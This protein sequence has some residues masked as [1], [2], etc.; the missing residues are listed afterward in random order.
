[1]TVADEGE[2][3]EIELLLPWYAAGTLNRREAQRV[4]A[5]LAGDPELA[6]RYELVRE[7]LSQTIQLNEALGAP[8]ARAMEM[9]FAKIDSEPARTPSS[10][11]SWG[12]RLRAFS[13]G[14]SPRTLAWSASVA[15]FAIVLEAA[16]IAG[17]IVNGNGVGLPGSYRA[18]AARLPS[19]AAAS[20]ALVQFQPQATA[21][22]I[23]EFLASNKL[24]LAGGPS[25]GGLYRVQVSSKKLSPSELADILKKLQQNS[26]VGFI[27]P[28]Q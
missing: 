11:P 22:E 14:L 23:G 8:S 28:T 19:P 13:A 15:A 6:R 24:S 27:A 2:G 5:A 26:V 20:Y 16:V 9:L 21:A 3:T 25:A 7:E 10:S 17:I 4:E 18:A 1:M 12:G